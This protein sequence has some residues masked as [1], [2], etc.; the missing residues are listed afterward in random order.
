[1]PERLRPARY[2]ATPPMSPPPLRAPKAERKLAVGVD[3]FLDWNDNRPHALGDRLKPTAGDRFKL[4]TIFNRG[5]VVWPQGV[6]E[7]FCTDQWRARFMANDGRPLEH[8]DIIALLE[9]VTATGLDFIKLENL[10]T[11]DGKPG[12]STPKLE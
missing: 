8:R 10:Y 4:Q 11:F 6:P 1:M 7:T 9:R 2:A 5:T 12:F 3:V